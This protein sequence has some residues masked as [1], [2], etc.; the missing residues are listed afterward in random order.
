MTAASTRWTANP[1]R[2]WAEAAS[3]AVP[4]SE[5]ARI[6]WSGD[7]DSENPAFERLDASEA[8]VLAA[9]AADY[10]AGARKGPHKGKLHWQ[11]LRNRKRPTSAGGQSQTAHI[12]LCQYGSLHSAV[13]EA[14]FECNP[15]LG[16]LF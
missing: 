2:V 3:G 10:R 12:P 16:C 1:P 9:T 8:L 14:S 15:K 5:P 4:S 11:G 6:F 7:F 13:L